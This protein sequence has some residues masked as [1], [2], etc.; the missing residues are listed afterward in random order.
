MTHTLPKP[1]WLENAVF[2]EIYPQTFYDSNADGI[3]DIP[4]IIQ[5]LDYIQSLGANAI[6]LNPCFQSPFLDAGYDVSDYYQV[7]PRYGANADLK[8]LFSEAKKRDMHVILDLVPGHTSI[9]HPWFKASCRHQPNTYTHY[10]IWNDS[11]WSWDAPGLKVVAGYAE[12]NANYITIFFYHQPALNYGFANPSLPWQQAVDAPGPMAVRQEMKN[13]MRFWLDQG[14]SGF[15]VDMAGSLVKGDVNGKATSRIWQDIRAWLDQNYPEAM[16]VSEWS[17]PSVSIPAG[18]HVDFLLHFGSPGWVSLFR[19]P[20]L[21]G[22][23]SDRYAFAFFNPAGHGN[24]QEFLDDYLNHYQKTKGLGLIALPTGNHDVNPRISQG[25]DTADL[26]LV[27]MF[28]MSMPGTP[29]IYYG[30]E[31][32][33]R[34]IQG[35]PS[36]E[37]GYNRTPSRTPMQWDATANA[38][39]SAAPAKSLYTPIDPAP[40][41]PT[42]SDQE[43]DAHSLLNR[44]RSLIALRK[45]HPAL[46]ATGD[47]NVVYAE[48]GQYPFVY[49]R[50]QEG[51]TLLVA[52][53]P[54]HLPIEVK[55]PRAISQSLPITLYGCENPFKS[56]ADGWMLKLPGVSG[57]IYRIA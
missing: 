18:F 55:L 33:M 4:G 14:A 24:I 36:K 8:R 44:L 6:W 5:K 22:P 7:A 51:E 31:I 54:S 17:N 16:L 28:L 21:S 26:D 40:D 9:E 49:T 35:L 12:R 34:S 20:D 3:G 38:G 27:Y 50:A 47:F 57:G 29:F 19:K 2:Y 48:A 56:A 15:R 46:C 45:S 23:G 53:N 11:A 32:G 43:A 30:D 41:R 13:V 1:A 37:G 10:F 42:V 25:R 39:F 52:L